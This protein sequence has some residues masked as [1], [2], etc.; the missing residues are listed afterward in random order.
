M[1]IYY[2]C[3]IKFSSNIRRTMNNTNPFIYSDDNKRYHTLNYYNKSSFNSKVFKA[4]ID[5]GFTCPNKDGTKG[6]GGCI[7]CMGGSGYFTE[8]SDG[9]IYDSVKRQLAAEKE[10]IYKKHP[11]SLITAYFQAN[12]NTYAPVATL[13]EAYTVAL[14]FGVHGISIG[15]RAD[16]LPDDV[17]ALLCDIN[18]KT[19]LTV[20]LGLQTIHD[21]SAQ[22]INRCY[23]YDEFLEGYRKLQESGIRTCLHLI[24]GLPEESLSD[25][26]ETAKEV[27][28]LHPA[29]VKIHLL[30][31]NH[32]TALERLFLSGGYVP[33]TR[34]EYIDIVISQLEYLPADIVIERITGDADKRCLV[35]PLWS[36]DKIAVLGGIDRQMK[37][38][39]TYQGIKAD[40]M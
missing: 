6:T 29:A 13:K 36:A 33:L 22:I 11:D 37:L 12:T 38:R 24:D 8:K 35:A 34:D 14:D 4:V 15:T 19:R 39:D 16:C 31:I 21:K 3:I 17:I 5:A 9:E 30:H 25:M 7:Y 20:E 32:G 27:A 40:V 1:Y 18:S 2:S 26:L 10:R 23:T 28:R